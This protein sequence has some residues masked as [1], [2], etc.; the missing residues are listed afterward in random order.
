[1]FKI[2]DLFSGAGGLS[3]G[4]DMVPGFESVVATDFN[5]PALKTYE[6][7]FPDAKVIYGNIVDKEVKQEIENESIKR[8]VNMIIG[9]PPC[10]GFSNKGK[11]LGLRDPRNFLFLEY[12]DMVKR[13]SP[14]VFV[15]E[16]VKAMISA[17]SGF[18]IN[19]IKDKIHELGYEMNIAILTASNYGVP[20][21]RQ[22]TIIIASKQRKAPEMPA[23]TVTTK[24]TVKDAISDLYYLNSGEGTFEQEY[25]FNA[26]SEYQ[27]LMRK[28][29]TKLFNH[30]ATNHSELALYKL[31]LIPAEKG[32][33]YLPEELRGKQLF[34]TTWG[35]LQWNSQSPTI[36]TRFDTPS[37]GTNSH[38]VLN[39]AITPREAARIQ[40]FPD[41]FVFLGK[42]TYITRQIG[43]AVPP[44]M[45]KAIAESIKK[46]VNI[47]E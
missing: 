24:T 21:N 19:E 25:K 26:K 31:S 1:M 42:K 44:L 37:N 22:R 3:K 28:H 4:F 16:N 27:K 6:R 17:A 46:Q 14:E 41:D 34:K 5:L 10:Q 13:L 36:D 9:G 33:E 43:N 40:S 38:P 8:N 20:Q 11:Q 35:R 2:L 39:R 45:A 18:F 23:P 12:L 29:S 7:N 47:F 32:K 15:I 30:V